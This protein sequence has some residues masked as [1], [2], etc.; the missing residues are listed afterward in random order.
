MSMSALS[1]YEHVSISGLR[2][3][4]SAHIESCAKTG[5]RFVVTDHSMP[6]AVLVSVSEWNEIEETLAILSDPVL[7]ANLHRV[8]EEIR[9]GRYLTTQ[10]IFAKVRGSARGNAD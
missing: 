10:E 7:S 6:K 1:S 9:A 5:R 4:L 8:D 2:S 3:N